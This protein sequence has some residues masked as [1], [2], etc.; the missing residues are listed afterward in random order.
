[1]VVPWWRCRHGTLPRAWL[2]FDWR[3]LLLSKGPFSPHPYLSKCMTTNTGLTKMTIWVLNYACNCYR[4]TMIL[5]HGY[6]D[7]LILRETVNSA[8]QLPSLLFVSSVT[9]PSAWHNA[10]QLFLKRNNR[11]RGPWSIATVPTLFN[12]RKT[13]QIWQ[14]IMRR[15][16]KQRLQM[17]LWTSLRQKHLNWKRSLW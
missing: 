12:K 15:N 4:E 2:S 3:V 8:R 1:M 11:C 5:W 14:L 16:C 7:S 6:R 13:R 9:W 17:R 10:S